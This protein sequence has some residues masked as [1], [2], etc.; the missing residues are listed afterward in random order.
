M[1]SFHNGMSTETKTGNWSII[2]RVRNG[3]SLLYK[4]ENPVD[5]TNKWEKETVCSSRCLSH[6]HHH[7][8][9]QGLG[10]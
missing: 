4:T 1:H 6:H 3:V 8:H 10:G 5:D 7:H 9:H 2:K